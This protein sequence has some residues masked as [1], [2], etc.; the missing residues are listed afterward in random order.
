MYP[1][2]IEDLH[3]LGHIRLENS[4][5]RFD[6]FCRIQ[7]VIKKYTHP[8]MVPSLKIL[9]DRRREQLE[10]NNEEGYRNLALTYS[11]FEENFTQRVSDVVL[12]HFRIDQ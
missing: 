4:E 7:M 8:A 5:L 2:L 6:D 12:E 11:D 3:L 10:L 1:D 9:I